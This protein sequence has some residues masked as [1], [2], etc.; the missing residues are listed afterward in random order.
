MNI[1]LYESKWD[2][3]LSRARL[4]T[5]IPFVELVFVAGSMAMGNVKKDSDFDFIIGVKSGR[6]F[7][8]RFFCHLFFGV[9]GWRRSRSME[10]RGVKDKFCFSHFVAPEKY[11]FSPPYDKYSQKLFASLVP[12]YGDISLIQKF[13][14]INADW[15]NESRIYKSDTRHV[16]REGAF[17]GK[18]IE[19]VLSGKLG[20]FLEKRLRKLQLKRIETSSKFDK[21]HNPRIILNDSELEFHPYTKVI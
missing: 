8:A 2:K 1:T 20:D 10:G 12:I 11:H 16:Y 13:F 17:L 6:I 21:L 7:T 14:D 3:L 15:M 19:K 5:I 4:F 18:L 9:L